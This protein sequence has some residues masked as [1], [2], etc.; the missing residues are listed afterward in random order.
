[1][2]LLIPSQDFSDLKSTLSERC[3]CSTGNIYMTHMLVVTI[4]SLQNW[5]ECQ[6]TASIRTEEWTVI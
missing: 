5:Q 6:V 1:M 3:I 2:V 4:L